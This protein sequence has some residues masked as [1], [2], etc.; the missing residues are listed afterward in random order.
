MKFKEKYH[1]PPHQYNQTVQNIANIDKLAVFWA[2]K[3]WN[4]YDAD[5]MMIG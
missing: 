5:D 4:N 3:T 2:T 1:V